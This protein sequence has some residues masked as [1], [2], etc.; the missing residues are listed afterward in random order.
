MQTEAECKV[1]VVDDHP[2][3]R[4]GVRNILEDAG[5]VVAAEA[6][7][8]YEALE[9][10]RTGDFDAVLLDIA[11]PDMNG[12]ETLKA[13]KQLKPSLPVLMLS[14]YEEEIYAV[15]AMKEGAAGYLTKG[16]VSHELVLAV[17]KVGGGGRYIT[18]SL[19]DKLAVAVSMGIE[20]PPHVALSLREFEVM[21]LIARGKTLKAIAEALHLSPKTITTYR[22]RILEKMGFESN[23]AIVQ[24]AIRNRLM[25]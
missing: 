20:K 14:I 25:D 12:I 1:L 24:Y 5:I 21:R 2:V 19:A 16:S 18:A 9:K 23:E 10:V 22:S 7:G 8:A 13:I 3:V 4:H 6:G 17:R 15:R 11:L